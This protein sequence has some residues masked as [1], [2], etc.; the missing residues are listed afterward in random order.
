MANLADKKEIIYG[1]GG[2]IDINTNNKVK[3]YYTEK[4]LDKINK[5][6]KEKLKDIIKESNLMCENN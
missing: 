5:N 2:W 1:A 4:S 6:D 3:V